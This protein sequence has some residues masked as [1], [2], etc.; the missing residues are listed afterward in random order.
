M[1]KQGNPLG[2]VPHM[3]GSEQAHL[4]SVRVPQHAWSGSWGPELGCPFPTVLH[5]SWLSWAKLSE[6]LVEQ[7]PYPLRISAVSEFAFG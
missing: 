1:Q 3:E 2:H 4:L 6:D 5:S 7:K